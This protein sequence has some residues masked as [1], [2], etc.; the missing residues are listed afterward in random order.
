[1]VEGLAADAKLGAKLPGPTPIYAATLQDAYS[2][3]A[4]GTTI[5]ATVNTFFE[6]LLF[7][8][9]VSVSLEGGKDPADYATTIGVTT[10]SGSLSVTDGTVDIKDVNIQ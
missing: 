9:P 2:L 10:V 4:D 1:M 8:R 5:L 6:D 3:V 7:N